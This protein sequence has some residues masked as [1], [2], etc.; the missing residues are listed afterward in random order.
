V[1][2]SHLLLDEQRI[3]A[4]W[5]GTTALTLTAVI[6][7]VGAW[8]YTRADINTVGDL[9][10]ANPL[11]IPPLL[12]PDTDAHGRKVFDL[13]LQRSTSELVPGTTSE[14]WGANGGYLGPTLRASRGD[15]VLINVDNHLPESTTVHW[16]GMHLPAGADGPASGW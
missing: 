8:L 16:H 14:T 15:E 2:V 9:D 13:D 11:R 4:V 5:G 1:V 12:D 3:E 7:A 6:V 10:F